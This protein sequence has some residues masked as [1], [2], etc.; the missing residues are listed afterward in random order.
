MKQLLSIL[1]ISISTLTLL[2]AQTFEGDIVMHINGDEMIGAQAEKMVFTVKDQLSKMVVYGKEKGSSESKPM[3]T[4]FFNK[5]N[6]EIIIMPSPQMAMKF[7]ASDMKAMMPD[8]SQ[9][10][11]SASNNEGGNKAM[12]GIKIT[13]EY[14]T[15]NGLKCRKTTINNEKYEGYTWTTNDLGFSIN[16]MMPMANMSYPGLTE[17]GN[18]FVMEMYSKDK[19]TGKEIK[20]KT[21]IDKKSIDKAEV[22]VPPGLPVQDMS[23]M[24]KQMGDNPQ[25]MEQMKKMM[26]GN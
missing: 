21:D 7:N 23:A 8:M 9:M 11:G 22:Q 5:A 20:M 16:D 1:F 4:M 3:A 17:M 6:D 13:D 18:G 14:K 2:S 25:M 10:G 19:K 24:M 12:D 15:I 26:G